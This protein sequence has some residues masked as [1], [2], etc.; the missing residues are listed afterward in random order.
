MHLGIKGRFAPWPPS[1]HPLF[2]CMFMN[3][4]HG[5]HHLSILFKLQT[6]GLLLDR[7]LRVLVKMQEN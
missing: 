3:I 4:G 5:V 7:L 2:L 6:E 1:I